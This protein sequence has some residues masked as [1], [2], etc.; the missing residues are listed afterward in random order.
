MKRVEREHAKEKQ[1]LTKDKDAG[2]SIYIF[3]LSMLFLTDS[4]SQVTT[5]QIE[6][7]PAKT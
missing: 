2:M 5:D 4:L 1:K 6:S 7:G 3:K